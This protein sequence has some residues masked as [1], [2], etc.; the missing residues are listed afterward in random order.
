MS[1]LQLKARQRRLAERLEDEYR[2]D[3][4]TFDQVHEMAVMLGYAETTYGKDVA[5]MLVKKHGFRRLEDGV[6]MVDVKE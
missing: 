3:P 2:T 5:R 6:Q 4:I 1:K